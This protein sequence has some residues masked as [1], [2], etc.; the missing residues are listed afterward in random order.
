MTSLHP[1]ELRN[2]PVALWKES[3]LW[4]DELVREFTVIASTDE[5]SGVPAGLVAFIEEVQ[6]QF[7]AFTEASNEE[8]EAAFDQGRA[9][10]DVTL[11][12]PMAALPAA[13]EMGQQI[14]RAIRYCQEGHL[15]IMDPTDRVKAFI[16]W[17]LTEVERQ[18]DGEEAHPW[19]DEAH[20]WSDAVTPAIEPRGSEG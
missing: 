18:L 13:I 20:P 10:V 5:D 8:L 14:E 15:L 19:S 6:A 9:H 12:L 2:L 16:H 3:R 11:R 4:F 17:Y 7:A 1:V